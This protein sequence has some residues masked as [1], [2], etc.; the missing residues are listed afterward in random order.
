MRWLDKTYTG[1]WQKDKCHGQ[2]A[3]LWLKPEKK[4]Y[5][6]QWKESK[7]H[8]QGSEKLAD[9]SHYKG[10]GKDGKQ[11]G[12]GIQKWAARDPERRGQ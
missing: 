6:G 5:T 10:G 1:G 7:Y 12:E 9:G 8:G 11:H 4:V 2:G 3:M